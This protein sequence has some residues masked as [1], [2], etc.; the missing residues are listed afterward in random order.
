MGLAAFDVEIK[1]PSFR[2]QR[3]ELTNERRASTANESL[4]YRFG[5]A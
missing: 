4:K 3:K 5:V 2:K 1:T